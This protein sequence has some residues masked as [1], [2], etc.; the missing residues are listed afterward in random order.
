[1]EC[2]VKGCGRP[3]RARGVCTTHYAWMRRHNCLPQLQPKTETCTVDGC[4][5][6]HEARGLCPMHY[7][8]LRLLGTT[9]AKWRPSPEERFWAKVDKREPDECWPW[10]GAH[11]SVGYGSF[12]DGSR[13]E[14]AIRF[15][16]RLA[17]GQIPQGWAIDH[18]CFNPPCVNP[19]H[20]EAVTYKENM[21][22]RL[23]RQQ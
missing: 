12:W 13:P 7:Q 4:D 17:G 19:A 10:L 14:R 22:R 1:M 23:I 3:A 2:S 16:Y 15:S 8:R 9:E 20:L 5:K 11:D 21:R 6:K 18:L